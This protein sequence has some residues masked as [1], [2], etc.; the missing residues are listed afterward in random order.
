[1]KSVRFLRD[2]PA[3]WISALFA[4]GWAV[5]R[6][7]TQS[8]VIDEADAYLLYAKGDLPLAL[9]PSSGNHVLN[10][11][12]VRFVTGLLGLNETTLRLPALL[13]AVLYIGAALSLSILL[14]DRKFLQFLLFLNLVYNPF[15]FDYLV[16]SR[17]YSLAIGFWLCAV[18]VMARALTSDGP[19]RNA[20][21]RRQCLLVSA[22]TALSF[23]AN[24]SFGLVDA[25]TLFVFFVWA[26]RQPRSDDA[27]RS[28]RALEFVAAC[29]L[30]AFFIIA[31]VCGITLWNWPKGELRF[32]SESLAKAWSSLVS[33][34]F[35]KLNPHLV[36]SLLSDWLTGM[37][38][39]LPHVTALLTLASLLVLARRFYRWPNP[40]ISDRG[41]VLV[42]ILLAILVSTF[43]LHW[44]AFHLFG[45]LLPKDRT[46]LFFVPLGVLIFGTLPA[47]HFRLDA[48]RLLR[49]LEV[50]ALS[51]AAVY[52]VLCLRLTHFKEWK[53]NSDSRQIYLVI[54]DLNRRCGITDISTEWRYV[55]VLNFYRDAYRNTAIPEFVT[56]TPPF[57]VDRAAYVLYYLDVREFIKQQGLKTVYKN[58]ETNAVVAIRG[59]EQY[60]PRQLNRR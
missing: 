48:D 6:A 14:T 10:T 50:I 57:P 24:F 2:R 37:V 55:G 49:W 21:L 36:S 8:V 44:S 59:C 20:M 26:S 38:K 25:V 34:S 28:I 30:P 54:D 31:A 19:G 5:A 9:W 52:F 45:L 33:A 51:L 46:A 16:A 53:Y 56:S 12:L 47:M 7:H 58:E 40:A 35:D 22:C 32:G 1:M 43:M 23:T 13:G 3:L 15:V 42:K 18:A 29:A 39:P 11:L 27:G 41:W 4:L 17:G 60:L